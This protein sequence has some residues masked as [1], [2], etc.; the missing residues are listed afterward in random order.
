M[1]THFF[2]GRGSF[3][4][5]SAA[6]HAGGPRVITAQVWA[7][8][9]L[10][11]ACSGLSKSR[12]LASNHGIAFRRPRANQAHRKPR[13]VIFSFSTSRCCCL[14]STATVALKR[15]G[16][17]GTTA[18]LQAYLFVTA[19]NGASAC[20]CVSVRMCVCECVSCGSRNQEH[21]L[22]KRGTTSAFLLSFATA[23]FPC[24]TP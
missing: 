11:G 4:A 8:A 18:A 14:W 16:S 13:T 5:L 19:T 2:S 6:G 24:I 12:E 17:R 15:L 1:A 3:L 10:R 20:V 23:V 9:G 22:K 21:S 7:P